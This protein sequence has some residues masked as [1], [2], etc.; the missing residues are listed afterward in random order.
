VLK[1]DKVVLRAVESGD[2]PR[3]HEMSSDVGVH[4]LADDEPFIPHS[5]EQR[6]AEI[7]DWLKKPEQVVFFVIEADGR[8]IGD[9][10]LHHLDSTSRTCALGIM[11]GDRAYWDKGYGSAAVRILLDYAFRLRNF[12]KVWLTVRGDNERAVR[13][14]TKCGFVEEGRMRQ[15]V[16][17]DGA[18]RD[19][20]YMGILR[21]QWSAAAPGGESSADGGG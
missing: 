7:K 14:Y 18:Y 21:E 1:G 11:I 19:W 2:F 15:Q 20:V 6:E 16:W 9:C 10:A 5:L 12:H 8:L 4:L 17:I 3:L 13:A